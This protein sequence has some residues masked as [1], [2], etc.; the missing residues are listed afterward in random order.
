[1]IVISSF[2]SPYRADR[3][4][5]LA[6]RLD[7][8][9]WAWIPYVRPGLP[10]AQAQ[11][12]RH[13]GVV[14]PGARVDDRGGEPGVLDHAVLVEVEAHD[15]REAV[16]AGVERV[17]RIT[18]KFKLSGWDFHPQKT[19]I[20]VRDV[21]IGGDEV[22]VIAG[23]CSVESEE[24]TIETARAVKA[25]G[26]SILRGGAYK[27]RTSPY[28]F[29]GLGRR[30]QCHCCE[31]GDRSSKCNGDADHMQHRRAGKSKGRKRKHGGGGG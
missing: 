23:P 9:R 26:A 28:E 31:P 27:P 11:R 15:H 21:T 18:K 5:A 1:M 24:Q 30:G 20:R 7:G 13:P 19:V 3:E 6:E 17:V 8:L 22:T 25:A 14:E 4:R 12:R 10:L 2:I 29:R 16:H